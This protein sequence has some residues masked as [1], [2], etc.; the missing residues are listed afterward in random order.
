MRALID[1]D[2]VLVDFVGGMCKFHNKENPYYKDENHGN[3]SLGGLIGLSNKEFFDVPKSFWS[4]LEWMP[5]GKDLLKM[6]EDTFG[7]DNCYIATACSLSDG[8]A[9]G[10]R[11]WLRDNLPDYFYKGRYLLGK[12]KFLMAN[13]NHY[14][15]DD[16]PSNIEEF[17]KDG[18]NGFLIKR[19][20]NTAKT[21]DG[22]NYAPELQKYL[23]G[24]CI[25]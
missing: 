16:K 13:P 9:D 6:I 25:K 1:L 7:K 14:L 18:G 24:L 17:Y 4:K 12:P 11:E 21:Y 2:G 22:I 19:P 23:G 3:F 8:A 20:W 10:K 15:F 5:D